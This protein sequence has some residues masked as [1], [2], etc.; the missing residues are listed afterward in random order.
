[1]NILG[2]RLKEA[3]K[4]KAFTQME[5][6]K[7]LGISHGTL[8][9]YERGYRD[10]D[11]DILNRLAQ[12]YEVSADW[13]LGNET[14]EPDTFSPITEINRLLKEYDIKQSGFY[15]IDRWKAMGAEEIKELENY[16]KYITDKAKEK[17]KKDN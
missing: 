14:D 17:N 8:S 3:R 1:M 5:V 16:F 12:L 6:S 9:G 13:L 4:S 10:P 15:E 11:T 7:K 2:K